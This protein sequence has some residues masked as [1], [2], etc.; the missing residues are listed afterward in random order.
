MD[1]L[2]GLRKA[3]LG[4]EG[5]GGYP[6]AL[7]RWLHRTHACKEPSRQGQEDVLPRADGLGMSPGDRTGRPE[8]RVWGGGGDFL[9]RGTEA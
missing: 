1:G 8:E 4:R 3:P 2:P 9:H 7:I 6:R 5:A